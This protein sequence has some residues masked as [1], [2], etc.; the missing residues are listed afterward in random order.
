MIILYLFYHYN[1]TMPLLLP[2]PF[3]EKK[4][5]LFNL[6]LKP[7]YISTYIQITEKEYESHAQH[8][9]SI[10]ELLKFFFYQTSVS[11]NKFKSSVQ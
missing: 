5:F 9:R 6:L 1:Q 4:N 7:K 8:A 3:L 11:F 10:K 2:S